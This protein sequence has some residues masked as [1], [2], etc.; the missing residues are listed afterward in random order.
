MTILS[1]SRK[2]YQA[3]LGVKHLVT[4]ILD[5]KKSPVLFWGPWHYQSH[6]ILR[7]RHSYLG[8]KRVA[9]VIR[10]SKIEGIAIIIL[11]SKI[12]GVTSYNLESKKSPVLFWNQKSHQS[13][14][15]KNR[16]SYW[17]YPGAKELSIISWSRN[18]C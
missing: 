13:V 7:S 16:N 15:F 14:L 1:W 6:P 5:S 4:L 18:N 9:S 11:E 10:E 8:V 3:Y 2:N 17:S 12:E